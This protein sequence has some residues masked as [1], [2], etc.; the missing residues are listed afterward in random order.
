MTFKDYESNKKNNNKKNMSGR[1][2]WRVTLSASRIEVSFGMDPINFRKIVS[3]SA[4]RV[5]PK[6]LETKITWRTAAIAMVMDLN[7]C[8]N[9]V[10]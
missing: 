7:R 3:N 8:K 9:I 6:G 10:L 4:Y 1:T 2:S 5:H